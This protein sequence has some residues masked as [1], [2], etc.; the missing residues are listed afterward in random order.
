MTRKLHIGG[1]IHITGWEVLNAVNGPYVDH[2]GDARDLSQFQD[3]T[4]GDLYASHVLE[5]MDY[6]VELAAV[7]KEWHRVLMPG[8]KI[9]ISVPD[10][11]VLCQLF[12]AKDKMDINERF[13]VMRMMFGGHVDN[14]DYHVVGL[15]QEF[16]GIFLQQAGFSNMRRVSSFGLFQDTSNLVVKGGPISVNVIAEKT[17]ASDVQNK[18]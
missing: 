15:N 17:H 6:K 12:M 11:D 8:G 3:D 16:L 4:F 14:Y 13:H 9:Y 5:H 10:M 1:K 7:L 18:K 2:L